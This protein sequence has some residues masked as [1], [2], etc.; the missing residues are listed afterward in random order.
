M[1]LGN[2][3]GDRRLGDT[4]WAWRYLL[5]DLATRFGQLGDTCLND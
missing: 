5:N 1:P 2:K 4:N 3:V